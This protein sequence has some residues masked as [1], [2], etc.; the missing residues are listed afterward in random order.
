MSQKPSEIKEKIL[1]NEIAKLSK[2]NS[3]EKNE[4]LIQNII[5]LG[6]INNRDVFRLYE[7]DTKL[8]NASYGLYK[9]FDENGDLKLIK[10]IGEKE[11]WLQSDDIQWDLMKDEIDKNEA[12]IEEELE[13]FAEELGISSEDLEKVAEI[14]LNQEVIDKKRDEEEEEQELDEDL[15]DKKDTP[16]KSEKK[17]F[18]Q[19]S[20]YKNVLTEIN[21]DSK[22]NQ[23][24]MTLGKALDLDYTKIAVVHADNLRDIR[25]ENGN[26]LGATTKDV[27]IIGFKEVDGKQIVE[28]VPDNKLRY[29]RGIDNSTIRFDSDDQVEKNN[30]TVDR[31]VVPGTNKGLAVDMSEMQ[32]KVYYQGGI[33]L[34]DNVAVMIRV[35]DKY[36]GRNTIDTETK[37]LFNT[38]RGIWNQDKIN[39][40]MEVHDKDDG[41][42]IDRENADGDFNSVGDHIHEIERPDDTIM[43]NGEEK[44]VE[45]VAKDMN[46]PT[47]MFIKEYNKR[48]KELDGQDEIDMKE[49]V[50]QEIEERAEEK[51]EDMPKREE[52]GR[53]LG[54]SADS[55]HE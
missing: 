42:K 23:Q 20:N 31:F 55:R 39:E 25:D 29:Y 12:L 43:Y 17:K 15:E 53:Y 28:K 14:D 26:R 19:T 9:Y 21:T 1:Q 27:A 10:N 44:T 36:T 32:T 13:Q 47:Y 46:I 5:Y 16:E 54:D 7:R 33:D 2:I 30:R 8:D 51:L 6:K 34:D 50:Y 22:V 4:I 35:E 52:G 11:E 41:E 37:E 38:N 24:G 49:D 40:E 48:A 3:K 45:Q 18:E